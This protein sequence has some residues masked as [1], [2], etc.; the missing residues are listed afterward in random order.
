VLAGQEAGAELAEGDD[1]AAL[2]EAILR[3][4]SRLAGIDPAAI[5][6]IV[7]GRFPTAAAIEAILGHGRAAA[8]ELPQAGGRTDVRT[9]AVPAPTGT[10]TG[11]TPATGGPDGSPAAPPGPLPAVL[12]VSLRRAAAARRV[13]AL[14]PSLASRLTIATTVART[15]VAAE[16]AGS[17]PAGPRWVEIDPNAAFV[18]DLAALGG[19]PDPRRSG[20]RR[21]VST[22]VHPRRT[23]LRRR[24]LRERPALRAAAERAAVRAAWRDVAGAAGERGA[25]VV[26]VGADD[27]AV[28]G[29]ALGAEATLAPGGLRWLAD[30]WDAAGRP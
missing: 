16:R 24:L 20:L 6:S 8:A 29:S 23:I 22:C 4:R 17:L 27:V 10:P 18:S 1:A 13:A 5:R 30:A 11:G 26:A 3:L 7:T 21:L 25:V 28:V 9:P 15:V 2:A 19:L 12:V 14:P